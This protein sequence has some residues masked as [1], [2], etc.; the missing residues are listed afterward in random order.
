MIVKNEEQ[1]LPYTLGSVYKYIDELIVVDTGST[2]KT[3]QILE[4]FCEKIPKSLILH[5]DWKWDFALARNVSQGPA[6]SSHIM[7]LDGDEALSDQGILKVRRELITDSSTD[8]WLMPRVNFWKDLK[9]MFAYP[10]SQYKIYRNLKGLRWKSKIHETIYQE[11]Y[12]DKLKFTDVPIFHYAYVKSPEVVAE[13]MKNYIRIENPSLSDRQL[14]EC[15]TQHSFFFDELP[16]SVQRYDKGEYP[17]VFDRLEVTKNFIKEKDGQLLVKFK[18]T[19]FA[20]KPREIT[21]EIKVDQ[22]IDLNHKYKDIKVSIVIATYNKLDYVKNCIYSIY[23]HTKIPFEIILIDNGSTE[24]VLGFYNILRRSKDNIVYKR[25]EE[26]TGFSKGYNEG[27]KLATGEFIC[28]LNND[29]LFS[30]DFIPKLL[31]VYYARQPL[32]DAGLIGPISNNNP[33]ENGRLVVD[34]E[35]DFDGYLNA[36]ERLKTQDDFVPYV[37]SSWMTG[38]CYLFHRDILA[39]LA[40]IEKPKTLG[41]LFDERLPIYHND[42][43]INWRIQHRLKKK[44]WIAREAFLW[45]FGS[46]TVN[47]LGQEEYNKM[48]LD[49]QEVLKELWPEIAG[50]M[51]F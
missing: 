11:K 7:W 3:L 44:M 36:H 8:F 50:N 33:S 21:Q 45:H 13:K 30:K 26:N 1:Y 15:K 40:A 4:G 25:F 6:E 14:E 22:G 34:T 19:Q 20:P 31:E 24:N 35:T 47:T 49:S 43:E 17:Q 38:L 41:V 2:D 37:E 46:V 18:G 5:M 48:K 32:G 27:V 29:T 10:D 23:E 42:T 39:D 28:V 12:A 9:H 51:Q 16:E